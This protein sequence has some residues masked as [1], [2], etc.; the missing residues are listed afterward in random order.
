MKDKIRKLLA[1]AADPHAAPNEA[2]TAARQAAKLMAKHDIDLADLE[3]EDL[4]KAWD[5]TEVKAQGCRPGKKNPTEVPPW[6]GIIAWGVK[7]Y[8]RTR[9]S[10]GAGYVRFKGPREDVELAKWLHEFL[11]HQAYAASKGLPLGEANRFRNG[12]ASA[13]QGRLKAMARE[14]DASDQE[15]RAGSSGTALVKVQDARKA[16]M[17]RLFGE[18]GKGKS[19]GAKSNSD[20]YS[21]GLSASIPTARPIGGESRRLLT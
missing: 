15:D 17:D 11:L 1:L 5:M 7:I 10:N 18:E 14:R 19:S 6:I 16:E 4:R 9:A 12:F 20:G 3:E 8:T 21:A 13:L 2:E